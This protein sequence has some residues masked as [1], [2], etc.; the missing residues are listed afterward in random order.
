MDLNRGN[1]K[2]ILFIVIV[3]ILVFLAMQRVDVVIQFLWGCYK[4]LSPL[5]IGLCIAFILNVLLKFWEEYVFRALNQKEGRI[6][7]QVRRGVCLLLT[8][9]T[10]VAIMLVLV[11][12]IMPEIGRSFEMLVKNIPSYIE[13]LQRWADNLAQWLNLSPQDVEKLQVDWDQVINTLQQFFSNQ[14]SLFFDTTVGI[15]SAI[16]NGVFNFIMGIAFSVY[17]LAQKEKLCRQLRKIVLAFLPH[18]KA[19]YLIAAGKL[20]NKIF[21]R[22]VTGQLTEAVIIGVLCFFGMSI[23]SMPYAALI[24]TIVGC[25]SLIPIFGAFFGTAVGAFLLLMID[26]MTA[27]WFVLFIIILQQ[28]ESNVIYPRV[29]GNSVGLPGIWVLFTV[30]VGGG[31]FGIFGMLV[32]IPIASVVYCLFKDAVS[33]RLK[34]QSIGEEQIDAA[35]DGEPLLLEEK[36]IEREVPKKKMKLKLRGK[37]K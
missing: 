26:P 10:V 29:V 23:F 36:E 13:E 17:M 22:F 25:T 24:S 2:K 1:I 6:W 9:G 8:Y 30:L 7:P 3:C 33:S 27:V 4:L 21:A 16:F 11:F 28:V 12:L 15:T 31:I 20:S 34:R 5:I 32:G 14:S 37:K 18:K 19:E 35:G